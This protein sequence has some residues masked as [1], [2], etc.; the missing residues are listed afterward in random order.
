MH[1]CTHAHVHVHVFSLWSRT[2]LIV[3]VSGPS[4]EL[5]APG[6][7][8]SCHGRTGLTSR[9]PRAHSPSVVSSSQAMQ[10]G[11][12]LEPALDYTPHTMQGTTPTISYQ[13]ELCEVPSPGPPAQV[14]L[15]S[16]TTLRGCEHSMDVTCLSVA[17]VN[18]FTCLLSSG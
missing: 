13:G 6:L 9:R 14:K 4:D 3:P 7:P 2:G 10:R 15:P 5:A 1:T 18:L 16:V 17:V 12:A 11:T 8:H